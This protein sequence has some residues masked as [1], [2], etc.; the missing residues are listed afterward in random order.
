MG[1]QSFIAVG[2]ARYWPKLGSIVVC[3]SGMRLQYAV[4]WVG[5]LEKELQ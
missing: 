2:C 4:K 1:C 3:G 5:D